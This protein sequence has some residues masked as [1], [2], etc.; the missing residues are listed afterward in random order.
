[1]ARHKSYRGKPKKRPNRYDPNS[2]NWLAVHYPGYVWGAVL[3]TATA[4]K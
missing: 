2:P 1:M 4:K 3:P